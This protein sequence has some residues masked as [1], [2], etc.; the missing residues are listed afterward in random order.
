MFT[1]GTVVLVDEKLLLPQLKSSRPKKSSNS[2]GNV[3]DSSPVPFD[4]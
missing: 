4:E 3:S 2:A 1:E